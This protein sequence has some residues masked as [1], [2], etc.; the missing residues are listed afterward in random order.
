MAK[1]FSTMENSNPSSNPSIHEVSDPA[2]R[3]VVRGGLAG[4]ATSLLAPLVAGCTTAGPHGGPNAGSDAPVFAPG[5][6]LGF[7]SVPLSTADTVTVPP[8]YTS[9]VIC[10]WGDPVGVPGNMPAFSPAAAN[11]A[12]EQAV[13]VGMHHDGM[14]FFPLDGSRR[15][16]LVLNNEYTDDGLLHTDLKF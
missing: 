14:H 2:R 5:P 3:I 16:V 15:G 1:D 10:K 11:T 9:A 12:A 7:K 6:Q 8:G 4:A 13:Q